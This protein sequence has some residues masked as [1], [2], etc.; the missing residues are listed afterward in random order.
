MKSNSKKR[1][2]EIMQCD[3]CENC[4]ARK[5]DDTICWEAVQETNDYRFALNICEDCFVYVLGKDNEEIT[6][7][8]RDKIFQDRE[9]LCTLVKICAQRIHSE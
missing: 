1:C 9:K 3:E 5:Q 7:Q 6:E 2:W 8:E 4:I